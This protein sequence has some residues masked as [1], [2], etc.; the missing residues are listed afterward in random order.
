[1][2]VALIELVIRAMSQVLPDRC[3]AGGYQIFGVDLFRTDPDE[4]DLFVLSDLHDGGAGGRPGHDGPVLVFSGDGDTRNTPVE[5]LETRFPVRMERHALLPEQAGPGRHR[6]GSGVARDFRMLGPGIRMQFTTEN[7]LD[8]LAKGLRGGG[9][10]APGLLVVRPGTD[11]EEVVRER[12]TEYWPFETGDV[13]SVRSGGGGGWGDPRDR[14]PERV[15]SDVL[16][17]Y[18]TQDAARDVYGVVLERHDRTWRVNG[19]AT[20]RIRAAPPPA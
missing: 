14:D 1:V 2:G 5:V 10:G 11:R 16:D 15:A 8:T 13:I 19:D 3:P 12:V 4:G 20:A 9:D 18:V 17:G 7:V 6:G